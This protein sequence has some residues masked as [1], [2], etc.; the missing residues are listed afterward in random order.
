MNISNVPN[1]YKIQIYVP[2]AKIQISKLIKSLAR[3]TPIHKSAY[4]YTHICPD[5]N[6][7]SNFRTEAI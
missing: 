2:F 3:V 7:C 1:I 4:T 6:N 5:T